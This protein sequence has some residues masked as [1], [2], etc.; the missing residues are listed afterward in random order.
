MEDVQ[1]DQTVPII[2]A[3]DSRNY[4]FWPVKTRRPHFSSLPQQNEFE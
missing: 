3:H 4:T 2:G 1:P